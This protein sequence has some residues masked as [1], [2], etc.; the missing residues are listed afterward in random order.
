MA[1]GPRCLA[2]LDQH[3]KVRW[4][5]ANVACRGITEAPE[6]TDVAALL[7]RLPILASRLATAPQSDLRELFEKLQLN[8][9]Y[10]PESQVLDVE[11]TLYQDG[12]NDIQGQPHLRA[13]DRLAPPAV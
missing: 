13:E 11:I 7:N 5:R 10:Q 1:D 6:I 9:A 8:I 3:P 2:H 12:W 4:K